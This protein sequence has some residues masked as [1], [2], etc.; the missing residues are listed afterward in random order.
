MPLDFSDM[1][2][3]ELLVETLQAFVKRSIPIRFGVVPIGKTSESFTQ[4]RIVYDL[5]ET[6]GLSSVFT[7]LTEVSFKK[8]SRDS[9]RAESDMG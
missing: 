2:D 9:S 4:T 3:M 1:K 6:Y 7:Y 8:K 5:L